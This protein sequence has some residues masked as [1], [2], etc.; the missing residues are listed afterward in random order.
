MVV[1]KTYLVSKFKIRL[2]EEQ[3]K[4]KKKRDKK[5]G[6]TSRTT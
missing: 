6:L 2:Q 5:R 4:K 1:P 3:D